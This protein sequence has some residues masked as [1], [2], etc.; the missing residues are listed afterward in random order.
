MLKTQI[1]Q[2]VVSRDLYDARCSWDRRD[3]LAYN[4]HGRLEEKPIPSDGCI[5]AGSGYFTFRLARH[6]G[7]TGR[8]YAVDV[9]PEMVVHPHWRSAMLLAAQACRVTMRV[10]RCCRGCA[11]VKA[12]VCDLRF[13]A[14]RMQSTLRNSM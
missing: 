6:V 7:D 12:G 9:S 3:I 1:Q 14:R 2:N 13:Q 11:R 5:G 4:G 8:V 10:S